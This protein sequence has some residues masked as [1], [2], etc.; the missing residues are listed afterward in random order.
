ME[1]LDRFKAD[2]RTTYLAKEYEKLQKEKQDLEE[3]LEA[4]STMSELVSSEEKRL[5][6]E[7]LGL[8]NQMKK[9]VD[10][11]QEEP[12]KEIVLE[13]R[14]GA[15]GDEAALFARNLA[16]MYEKFSDIKGWSYIINDISENQAGGYKEAS[17]TIKGKGVYSAL[18][19]ETGVHRI[20]RIPITEKSGRIH[21][22]TASVA[23]LPIR[24][25]SNVVI[26]PSDIKM[27]F[28][29]SGGAGGQNVKQ[30]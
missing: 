15:G 24:K 2:I 27:E 18:F 4:D 3:L 21:T 14:A 5:S 6:D 26:E 23:I 19:F 28:S 16:E 1:S 30:S 8:L 11:V 17:F 10:D 22:S 29:R 20:Q 25:R 9:I 13:V 12:P 7:M